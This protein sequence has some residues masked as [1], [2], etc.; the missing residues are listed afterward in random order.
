MFEIKPGESGSSRSIWLI[1]P[2]ASLVN[3]IFSRIS[4]RSFIQPASSAL[5]ES[6]PLSH[7]HSVHPLDKTQIVL[8]S[9]PSSSLIAREQDDLLRTGPRD[10]YR[11]SD[12]LSDLLK[13]ISLLL[14]AHCLRY[15]KMPH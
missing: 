14:A 3:S 7:R 2:I 1:L 11:K 12:C 15:Q 13:P 6:F 5:Y 9:M 10:C 8:T 4:A